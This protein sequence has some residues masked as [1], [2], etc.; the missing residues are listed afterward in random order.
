MKL[1]IESAAKVHSELMPLVEESITKLT[2]DLVKD[3]PSFSIRAV[4]SVPDGTRTDLVSK[5][6][7]DLQLTFEDSD[8]DYFKL[9]DT[10][11]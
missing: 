1:Q 9:R 8:T 4:G 5:P 3:L 2:S 10:I 11:V 6:T 7:V